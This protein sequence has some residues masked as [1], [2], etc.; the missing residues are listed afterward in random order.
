[1]GGFQ[2][3]AISHIELSQGASKGG[4]LP[5]PT[6]SPCIFSCFFLMWVSN[7]AGMF[8]LQGP[9][10]LKHFEEWVGTG[11]STTKLVGT[12]PTQK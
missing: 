2:L 9:Q 11:D 3:A 1:M 10:W 8:N 7:W 6:G 5:Y 12:A 4:I